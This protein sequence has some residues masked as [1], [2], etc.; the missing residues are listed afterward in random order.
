MSTIVQS[1]STAS[2]LPALTRRIHFYA[3]FF[4]ASFIFVAA[5]GGGLYALAPTLENVFYKNV[6]TVPADD[7]EV[8]LAS[9]IRAAQGTHPEME[10]AQVWPSS[11]PSEPTRVLL[12]DESIAENEELRSVLVN[13][14]G[15]QVIGDAPSYSGLGELP[16]RHWILGAAQKP[17]HR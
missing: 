14:H 10:V 4:I 17:P 5:L 13:P 9:Q 3:G 8:A 15:G 11:S 7:G 6:L 1:S 2:G 16:L 12:I